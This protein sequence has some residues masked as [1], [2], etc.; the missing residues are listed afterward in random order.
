MP[1]DDIH[2]LESAIERVA[3]RQKLLI[4]LDQLVALGMRPRTVSARV[5]AR[6][7]FRVHRSVF[8]LHP[9]PYSDLQRYLAAVFACRPHSLLSDL[10]SAHLLRMMDSPPATTDVTVTAGR[11]S[12]RAGIT[13]HRRVIEHR[14]Q[15]SLHGIPCTSAART[16][17]DC[18]HALGEEGTEDLIMAAD[19]LGILRRHR[20]E[21]LALQ[22]AG[23]PGMR[24]VL[25]P[26]RG[27]A[28]ADEKRQ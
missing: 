20:L 17:I 11:R 28:P 13:V 26:R 1:K 4:R 8:A 5:A 9:P 14:D 2:R 23:R 19:S 6:R 21:E 24:H 25:T 16:V 12:S 10:S 27:R 15:S 22:R 18:A 3:C 7:L